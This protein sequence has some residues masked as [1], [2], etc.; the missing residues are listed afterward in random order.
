MGNGGRTLSRPDDPWE[1]TGAWLSW[2]ASV[3]SETYPCGLILNELITN[4]LKH[5]F[6]DARQGTVRVELRMTHDRE[7]VLSVG[8]DGIG[9]STDFDPAKSDSLGVQL[10]T[11]LVEQL[12]G[13]LEITR[14]CGTIFSVTFPAEAQP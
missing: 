11:T 10:V 9:L 7:I 5:A 14:S 3:G 6:P 1:G 2:Y 13:R 8:D 12:E 4:A